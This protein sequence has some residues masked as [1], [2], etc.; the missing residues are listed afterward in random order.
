MTK[1]A[2]SRLWSFWQARIS[3]SLRKGRLANAL[4]SSHWGLGNTEERPRGH[5]GRRRS[6]LG[7]QVQSGPP[8]PEGST[9]SVLHKASPCLTQCQPGMA[10]HGYPFSSSAPSTG[11]HS[12]ATLSRLPS[13]AL[14]SSPLPF[15]LSSPPPFLLPYCSYSLYVCGFKSIS[16]LDTFKLI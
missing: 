7:P 1:L 10:Q 8:Y 16:K 14:P 6:L 11:W 3:L 4:W 5:E 2:P 13:T 9:L 15:L 12:M